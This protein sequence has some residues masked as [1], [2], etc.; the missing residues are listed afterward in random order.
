[1]FFNC[2]DAGLPADAPSSD[3]PVP[4]NAPSS[5][6]PGPAPAPSGWFG[7]NLFGSTPAPAPAPTSAPAPAPAPSSSLLSALKTGGKND[8]DFVD[9]LIADGKKSFDDAHAELHALLGEGKSDIKDV[10][11]DEASRK[12]ESDAIDSTGT[13]VVFKYEPGDEEL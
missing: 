13:Q 11:M 9:T 4:D 1:M 7:T 8:D 12:R 3:I 5:G 2:I 10:R 6:A